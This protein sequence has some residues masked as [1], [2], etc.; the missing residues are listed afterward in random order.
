VKQLIKKRNATNQETYL[1]FADLTKAYDSIPTVK[2]WEV[3]GES[4]INNTLITALQNLYGN[5]A[6]VKTGNTLSNPFNIT[7]GLR[8]GCCISPTLFKIYIRKALEEW[9]RKC[10]GMGAPLKNT[11]LYTLQFADDQVVLAG[12][13]ED[14]EYMTRKLK[15]TY[16][17]WGLDMNLNETKYLYIG[18]TQNNLKLDKDYEIEF[19][20][21]YKFLRVIFDTSGTDDKEIRS[22]VI[23]ARKCIACLNR[24]LWSKDIRKKR[25]LNIYNALIKSNLLYG[26]EIWRLTENNKRRVE[27]I[28]IEALR[29]SSRISRKDRIRNVTIKRHIGLEETTIKEI[30]QNQLT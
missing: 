27:A 29:K 12:D 22:R 28:E 5:T 26:S 4:N 13:K 3:L 8:Q 25:K 18:E 16:E 10:H 15:E 21:D 17:K 7:K 6:Q 14:L 19:Y 11:T 20:Q 23:Q 30:E 24:I 2:L 9:R 1:L